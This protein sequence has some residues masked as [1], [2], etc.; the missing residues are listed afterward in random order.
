MPSW[1]NVVDSILANRMLLR[2]SWASLREGQHVP[3]GV[4]RLPLG[5]AVNILLRTSGAVM[6]CGVYSGPVA[7]LTLECYVVHIV[8][9]L[10]GATLRL[11]CSYKKLRA[12]VV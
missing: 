3:L 4:G 6:C 1:G 11:V 2:N 12:I 10:G 7:L 8:H 5:P 9:D